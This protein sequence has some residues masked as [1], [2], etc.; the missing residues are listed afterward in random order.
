MWKST[1]NGPKS[2]NKRPWDHAGAKVRIWGERPHAP[3]PA[4]KTFG[5]HFGFKNIKKTLKI[6]PSKNTELMPR[7]HQNGAEIDAL[8]QKKV[9]QERLPKKHGILLYF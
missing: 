8:M 2:M 7:G 6:T 3:E 1:Q 4:L 9:V 5:V